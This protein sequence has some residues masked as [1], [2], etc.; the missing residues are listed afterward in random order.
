MT[1]Q[2]FAYV[3]IVKFVLHVLNLNAARNDSK[4]RILDN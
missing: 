3:S 4:A 2:F 1:A